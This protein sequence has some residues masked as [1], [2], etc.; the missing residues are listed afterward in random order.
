MIPPREPA[1][2][3]ELLQDI[4]YGFRMLLKTPVVSAIAALSL[5]LGIAGA[6]AMMALA[7]AFLLEPLP[8]G[9]QDG[10]ILM[11]QLRRGDGI[12][13][14]SGISMP[15]YRDVEQ[16][17][18]N[19]EGLTAFTIRSVNVTGVELPEQIQVV[20]SIPHVFDVLRIQPRVGRGFRED[21]GVA[22]VGDVIVLTDAYWRS[23]F[24]G[25]P[26]ALGSTIM[27]DGRRHTVIG[28][29]P[30]DFE[31]IPRSSPSADSGRAQRSSRRRRNWAARSPVSK[32]SIRK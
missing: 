31:M 29:M 11:Q 17:S 19:L 16:A 13:M 30:E 12:E 1:T 4:R 26:Q 9:D 27:L 32:P 14:A 8:F 15:N 18:T 3:T 23:H 10:L 5:A 2:M 28:V 25:D 7:S 24:R 20:R 21:E 22:G 6:T